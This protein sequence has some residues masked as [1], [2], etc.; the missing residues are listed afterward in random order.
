MPAGAMVL[1]HMTIRC[2]G[3]MQRMRRIQRR[4]VSGA[5]QNQS[6]CPNAR[7]LHPANILSTMDFVPC[8]DPWAAHFLPIG[9]SAVRFLSSP[10]I[11][12]PFIPCVPACLL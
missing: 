10:Q 8:I 9:H 12:H 1:Y 3:M 2:P 5:G 11:E 6:K 4:S 7:Q